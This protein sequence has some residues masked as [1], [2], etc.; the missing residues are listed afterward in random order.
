MANSS[1]S[2]SSSYIKSVKREGIFSALM[3]SFSS[4]SSGERR[5][6]QAYQDKCTAGRH[7]QEMLREHQERQRQMERQQAETRRRGFYNPSGSE[8]TPDRSDAERHRNELNAQHR[9]RV[10]RDKSRQERMEG[11]KKEGELAI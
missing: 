10:Q 1:S 9:E 2:S 5:A 6:K 3:D 8:G 11:R 4:S 7:R